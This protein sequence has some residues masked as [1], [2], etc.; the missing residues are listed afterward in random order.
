MSTPSSIA[1]YARISSDPDGTALGVDRQVVDCHRDAESQGW[2]VGQE[3][4]DNDVSAFSKKPRPAF[5]QMLEDLAT[6][7]RDGVVCYHIDRLTRRNKDL[8]RFL[9]AVDLG[10]VKKVRFVTGSTDLGSG[11]GLLVARIM[12]A[13][14]ESESATKSR[15]IRRKNQE[16]AAQGLPHASPN[17]AFRLRVRSGDGHRV[18]S[19]GDSGPGGTVVGW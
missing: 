14:A 18:R 5:E 11:D 15:R 7:L 4:V 17:R 9:E 2:L 19:G 13:V 1:I 10:R 6:G 8:D 3:Y 16:K 12:A